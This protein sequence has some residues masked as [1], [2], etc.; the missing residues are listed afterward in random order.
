[1]IVG[2]GSSSEEEQD[3]NGEVVTKEVEKGQGRETVRAGI[4]GVGF[5]LGLVG[6]WG[7][8]L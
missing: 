7:D 3:V 6:I 4:Y 2:Q 1:M 5:V 8:L